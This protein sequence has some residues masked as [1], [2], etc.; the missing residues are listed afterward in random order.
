MLGWPHGGNLPPASPLPSSVPAPPGDLGLCLSS[1]PCWSAASW[2]L[3]TFV[4]P[5]GQLGVLPT[6][7][8]TWG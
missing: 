3:V 5:R 8:H 7:P 1:L 4:G 6:D 2:S